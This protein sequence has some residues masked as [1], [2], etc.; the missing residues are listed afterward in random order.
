MLRAV[1]RAVAVPEGGL[2]FLRLEDWDSVNDF[3]PMSARCS[4]HVP[5]IAAALGLGH[6]PGGDGVEQPSAPR[7]PNDQQVAAST[8]LPIEGSLAASYP[9]VAP[10]RTPNAGRP[11][12]GW[13]GAGGP[14][15]VS[16]ALLSTRLGT[17]TCIDVDAVIHIIYDAIA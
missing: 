3:F 6:I 10:R 16:G 8:G 11:G 14:S 9:P 5:L 17:M 7:G 1:Q 15:P 4:P 12:K 2:F 13:G